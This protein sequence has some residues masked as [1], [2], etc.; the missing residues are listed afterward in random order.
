M[1]T[2]HITAAEVAD[3]LASPPGDG[4]RRHMRDCVQCRLLVIRYQAFLEAPEHVPPRDI[5]AA[6]TRL[7]EFLAASIDP[8]PTPGRPRIEPRTGRGRGFASWLGGPTWRPALAVAAIALMGAGALWFA[9]HRTQPAPG[10]P[11]V[12]R[13]PA[14]RSTFRMASPVTLASGE[15]AIHWSPVPGADHYE[16]R[17]HTVDLRELGA[18]ASTADTTFTFA[19]T[20][21]PGVAGGD[22][23]LV[24]IS[25]HG[26]EAV[27]T[28]STPQ[29]LVLPHD[30][31]PAGEKR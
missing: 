12:M 26:G 21:L 9:A 1:S 3:V 22:T 10:S 5:A 20:T 27:L 18:A 29:P 17:F 11:P 2:P 15:I 31:G 24:S 28:R 6:E 8:E 25:A 16:V 19:P 14:E 7:A 4:R 30:F 13:G 23:V